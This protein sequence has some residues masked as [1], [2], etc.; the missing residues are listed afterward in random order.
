LASPDRVVY[1][2]EMDA[3]AK[4][5]AGPVEVGQVFMAVFRTQLCVHGCVWL[6]A[7]AKVLILNSDRCCGFVDVFLRPISGHDSAAEAA[8]PAASFCMGTDSGRP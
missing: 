5:A 1:R 6:V 4:R 8:H 2:S 3:M 7:F